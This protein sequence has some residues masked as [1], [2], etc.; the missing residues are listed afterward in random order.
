LCELAERIYDHIQ[1]G[2][3]D[4]TKL[5]HLHRVS[6]DLRYE[7]KARMEDLLTRRREAEDDLLDR[8]DVSQ[9][10]EVELY[11]GIVV[12]PESRRWLDEPDE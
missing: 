9:R 6:D 1:A 12:T 10:S 4:L 3:R 7:T 8:M 5:L 11:T 2:G